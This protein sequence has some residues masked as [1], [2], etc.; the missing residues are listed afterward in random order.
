MGLRSRPVLDGEPLTRTSPSPTR[1]SHGWGTRPLDAQVSKP[2]A[3]D[4]LDLVGA[5]RTLKRPNE[6]E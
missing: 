1:A 5:K 4:T 6:R 3:E 2:P